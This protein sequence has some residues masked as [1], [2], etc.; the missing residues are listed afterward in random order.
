[1]KTGK[2]KPLSLIVFLFVFFSLSLFSLELYQD[3]VQNI[4]RPENQAAALEWDGK[5]VIFRYQ[6]QIFLKGALSSGMLGYQ[7]PRCSL[8]LMEMNTDAGNWMVL[9]RISS[10]VKCISFEDLGLE[11]EKEYFVFEFWSKNLLGSFVQGFQP[12]DIDPRFRCQLFCIR[13]QKARA[14]IIATSRHISCG[15][16]LSKLSWKDLT[17]SS[18]S[19]VIEDD[20]YNLYLSEPK[21]CTFHDF[22]CSGV[23]V[24]SIQ[25]TGILRVIQ[26]K[27]EKTCSFRWSVTYK[28]SDQ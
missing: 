7:A 22:H 17:L 2:S 8:Y 5:N 10:E 3:E 21:G 20:L 6:G 26:M 28:K 18:E 24:E 9:G 25:K 4:T 1:M 15:H 16:E 19:E 27:S 12:G 14:Q 13:E 11:P 23:Q